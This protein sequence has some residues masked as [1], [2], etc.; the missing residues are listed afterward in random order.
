LAEVRKKTKTEIGI[1][2]LKIK[3]EEER[4]LELRQQKLLNS[5]DVVEKTK[6]KNKRK[7]KKKNSDKK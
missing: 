7:V 5:M 4:F 2:K 6:K 3:E 1:M